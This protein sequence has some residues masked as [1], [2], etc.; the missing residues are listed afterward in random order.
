MVAVGNGL[1][2][3]ALHWISIMKRI[4][5]SQCPVQAMTKMS[6]GDFTDDLELSRKVEDIAEDAEDGS[7]LLADII[8]RTIEN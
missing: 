8:V 3:T 5:L 1:D 2:T 6:G 4:Q 7:D